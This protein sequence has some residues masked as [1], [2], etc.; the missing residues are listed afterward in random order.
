MELETMTQENR[1]L[2]IE[3][4]IN[5]S[6][7]NLKNRVKSLASKSLAVLALSVAMTPALENEHADAA[8]HKPTEPKKELVYNNL[9]SDN[10]AGYV[11]GTIANLDYVTTDF[12]VPSIT[13]PPSGTKEVSMWAGSGVGSDTDPLYQAGVR[14]ECASGTENTSVW[15]EVYTP[16]GGSGA[17]EQDFTGRHV[18]A[19]EKIIAQV[20]PRFGSS[21]N[22]RMQVQDYDTDL[23]TFK[24]T[25]SHDYTTTSP[26]S[27]SQN[28]CIVERPTVNGSYAELL[29]FS[30]ITFSTATSTSFNEACDV[31]ANNTDHII[32]SSNSTLNH[33][34]VGSAY[35][36]QNSSSTNLA[37]TSSP[38]TSGEFTVTWQAGS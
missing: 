11:A 8:T 30:S 31:T 13:C 21:T 4:S 33:N 22:V 16:S 2:P 24:W 34:Y 18:N 6:E 38:S 19:G 17:A 5:E 25:S 32:S 37:T 3:A 28:E 9:S 35:D 36:M 26:P 15:W 27:P 1:R 20:L 12:I 29:N 23:N 14:L 7:L 10:W